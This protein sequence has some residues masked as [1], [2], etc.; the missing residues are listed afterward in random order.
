[1]SPF[2]MGMRDGGGVLLRVKGL[3]VEGAASCRGLRL[4]ASRSGVIE[5][6]GGG[7]LLAEMEGGESSEESLK[8]TKPCRRSPVLGVLRGEAAFLPLKE[9]VRDAD[10]PGVLRVG[11]SVA[12][13]RV[14]TENSVRRGVRDEKG[15]KRR[16]RTS[17]KGRDTR[18]EEAVTKR[19]SA[20]LEAELYRRFD[21]EVDEVFEV[22][23]DE[24]LAEELAGEGA[25]V[26]DFEL[27]PVEEIFVFGLLERSPTDDNLVHR[28]LE[29]EKKGQFWSTGSGGTGL[30]PVPTHRLDARHATLPSLSPG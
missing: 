19:R 15:R 24:V 27:L 12:V 23:G 29:G 26:V 13:V 1:M 11:V 30:L 2:R 3:G 8:K 20:A 4:L 14:P 21:H 25:G 16:T 9:G 18:L 7:G 5:E 22:G 17:G 6:G 28:N 10:V